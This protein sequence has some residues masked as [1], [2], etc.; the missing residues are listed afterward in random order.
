MKKERLDGL[1]IFYRDEYHR[2][3]VHRFGAPEIANADQ[4]NQFT[5]IEFVTAVKDRGCKLRIDGRGAW[6]DNVF[7]ERL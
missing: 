1:R 4:G 7:V 5:A 3:D 6:R 2:Q